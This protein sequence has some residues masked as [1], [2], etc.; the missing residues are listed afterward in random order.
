M[1]IASCSL[2]LLGFLVL[3]SNSTVF[4]EEL[5]PGSKGKYFNAAWISKS[6]RPP[7]PVW[8]DQFT[9][10][11]YVYVETYGEDFQSKGAIHYDWTKKVRMLSL[12]LYMHILLVCTC[13][14]IINI[15]TITVNISSPCIFL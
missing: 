15:H 3:L 9:S 11:F 1:N 4:C 8:P 14:C 12:T 13:T 6:P 5:R 2:S 10:D 7:I